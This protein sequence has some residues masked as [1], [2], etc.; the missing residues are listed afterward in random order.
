MN[1]QTLKQFMSEYQRG[2][3]MPWDNGARMT[4]R[5]CFLAVNRFEPAEWVPVEEFGAWAELYDEWDA[6][7]VPIAN[8]GF[9]AEDSFHMIF[10]YN[11]WRALPVTCHLLPAF[12]DKII[13]EQGDYVIRQLTNGSIVRQRRGTVSIPHYLEYPIKSRDDWLTFKQRLDANDPK[14]FGPGYDGFCANAPKRNYILVLF[15]GPSLGHVREWW[16][17]EE[18]CCALIEQPELIAEMMDYTTQFALAVLKKVLA[19]TTVDVVHFWEDLCYNVGPLVTPRLFA[20]LAGPF[21]K[22]LTDY[23]KSRGVEIA[24]VDC[25]GLI[26]EYIPIWLDN[27]VTCVFPLERVCG[28]DPVRYRKEYGRQL[29]LRGGV[30]KRALIEGPD[31]ILS[32]LKYLEPLIAE[33]GF[34][35]TVDHR[36]P[37][38]VP[39]EHFLYYLKEKRALLGAPP[40]AE[41]NIEHFAPPIS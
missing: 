40:I 2:N 24:A 7:G 34:I 8:E 22:K 11:Q 28:S 26:D 3:N 9:N 6:Q 39:L 12:E 13:E 4:A 35:P 32:Q 36:I 37:Q 14:R 5:E 33:G 29:L 41:T 30:D 20:E 18:F 15:L 31:A 38:G 23:A 17:L 27:G 25:D 10:R 1:R 21:Y 19:D 16:G